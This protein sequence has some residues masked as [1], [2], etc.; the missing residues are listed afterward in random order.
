M[1][2]APWEH[3]VAEVTRE[4]PDA[5]WSDAT[6][7]G[8]ATRVWRLTLRPIPEAEELHQVLADLDREREVWILRRGQVSHSP[9]CTDPPE[10]H[11]S[12]LPQLR[13]VRR[14]YLVELIYPPFS[15]GPAGPVHP[16]ARVVDPEISHRTYLT[17]PHMF[18]DP[19]NDDSWACPIS[20]QSTNWQWRRGATL[21]Y[22]DQVALWILKSAVWI[23]TGGGIMQSA[24]W[25]GPDTSHLPLDVLTSIRPGDLCRCGNG[26]P[27]ETC[28]MRRDMDDALKLILLGRLRR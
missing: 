23:A 9:Q 28:H 27:Y 18:V 7:G 22:L 11:P 12:V 15:Q 4:Y 19:K 25:L 3:E 20:P 17:H 6:V 21:Q 1:G 26:H 13:L 8:R 16:R 10:T 5:L 14:S 24:R 2:R